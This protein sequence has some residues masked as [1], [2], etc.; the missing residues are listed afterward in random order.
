MNGHKFDAIVYLNPQFSR[1]PVLQFLE[2]YV[3]K[4]GKLMIEGAA[5]YDFKGNNITDRYKSIA[6]KAI[7]L[8]YSVDN[9][10]MLGIT[11]NKLPDGCKN[12]DG[13]YVFNDMPS[14]RTNSTA[15]FTLNVDDDLFTGQYKG[16]AVI[17][18]SKMSGVKKLAASGFTELRKN[19][20]VI[21]SFKEPVDLF[22]TK[23]GGKLQMILDDPT[24]KIK[25]LVNKL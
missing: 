14:L 24:N 10:S 23:V 19:G 7:V 18:V 2:E 4:G 1:E 9:I 17:N 8:G 22:V 11:K 15:T 5:N 3:R 25:P 12:E 13:S 21:L 16:I 6:E 20:K